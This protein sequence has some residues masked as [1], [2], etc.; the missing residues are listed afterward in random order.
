[1]VLLPKLRV[2]D[3]VSTTFLDEAILRLDKYKASLDV[4]FNCPGIDTVDLAML[5]KDDSIPSSSS[6][7]ISIFVG[8][9]IFNWSNFVSEN[10]P[11]NDIICLRRKYIDGDIEQE[12]GRGV[13]CAVS[14]FPC[15][16]PYIEFEDDVSDELLLSVKSGSSENDYERVSRERWCRL[17]R[18]TLIHIH[19]L[20]ENEQSHLCSSDVITFP[21]FRRRGIAGDS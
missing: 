15:S 14:T 9:P 16:R 11:S 13:G 2:V 7:I 21:A 3:N 8:S 19:V 10:F 18:A 5:P 4:I 20:Q 17:Q 1:M 12:Q 6:I